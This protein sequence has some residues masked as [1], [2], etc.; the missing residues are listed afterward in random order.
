VKETIP[1]PGLERNAGGELARERAGR[2]LVL[3]VATL[4]SAASLPVIVWGSPTVDDYGRCT[5]VEQ[6]GF[7]TTLRW[8]YEATGVVRPARFLEDALLGGLCPHV[9]FGLIVLVPFLLTMG[10]A[11]LLYNLLRDLR[12]PA[13]WPAGGAS[14]WLL[15]PLGTEAA[16]WPSAL[17]VPMGLVFALLALGCFRRERNALG[18]LLAAAAYLSIEQAIF[19]LPFAALMVT[20]GRQRFRS[21]AVAASVSVA[22]LTAYRL[23][24]GD[25]PRPPLGPSDMI[26]NV[27]ADPF[28][29]VRFPATSFG[30]HSIPLSIAWAFP[31]SLLVLLLGTVLLARFAPALLPPPTERS[32][33][34]MDWKVI[35]GIVVLVGLINFPAM[36]VVPHPNAPRVFT[37][38]WLVFAAVAAI[39]GARLSW[40]R[41]RLAGAVA[42]FLMAGALLSIAF[43]VSV[44]Y[45]TGQFEAA[46]AHWLAGRLSPGDVVAICDVPRIVVPYAPNGDFHVH[47]LMWSWSGGPA[48]RHHTGID[49]RVRPNHAWEDG[50]PE[51]LHAT[52]TIPF[53]ELV[54]AVRSL[55]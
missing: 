13:P 17:H 16:L 35:A 45:R 40:R 15:Q 9:P 19:A 4:V 50:C 51:A 46:A 43:S 20:T 3:A 18:A 23:W 36:V 41:P 24:P 12:V 22:A 44:R 33:M 55:E 37:P 25:A 1:A 53:E 54:A 14:I 21:L 52:V 26:R 10:V 42:G 7:W 34:A 48:I 27:F 6:S 2:R 32:R 5:S 31:A 11:L 47:A 28:F 49:V 8:S 29:Y 38:T 39:G 30:L